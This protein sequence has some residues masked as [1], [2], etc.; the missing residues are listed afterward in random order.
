ML[1]D[2]YGFQ[3]KTLMLVEPYASPYNALKLVT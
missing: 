2:R 3:L 1:I